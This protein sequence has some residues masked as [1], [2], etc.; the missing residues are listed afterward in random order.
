MFLDDFRSLDGCVLFNGVGKNSN[1]DY[2]FICHPMSV[3][4]FLNQ[5]FYKR[6]FVRQIHI[7]T[8]EA[9]MR[10]CCCDMSNGNK[11]C[12]NTV[13]MQIFFLFFNH[14][15]TYLLDANL[16]KLKVFIEPNG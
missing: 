1:F 15:S 8:K 4:T 7:I 6:I 13:L 3:T 16:L 12:S 11:S 5:T 10:I 9:S 2:G 14:P